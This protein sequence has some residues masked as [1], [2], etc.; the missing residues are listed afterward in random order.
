MNA[1]D[2]FIS[3]NRMEPLGMVTGMFADAYELSQNKKEMEASEL[4]TRGVGILSKNLASKTFLKGLSEW[5]GMITHADRYMGSWAEGLTRSMVPASGLM[6]Q[7]ARALDPTRREVSSPFEAMKSQSPMLRSTLPPVRTATGEI[8][9]FGDAPGPN[10]A[11][12]FYKTE[13]S[14]D[15]V[16]REIGELADTVGFSLGQPKK[17]IDASRSGRG[18]VL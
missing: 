11:S 2:Q 10:I 4:I 9:E 1:E 15:P 13:I 5:L 6:G 18:A 7:T 3:Y 14:K 12:P 17:T 16:A 8:S